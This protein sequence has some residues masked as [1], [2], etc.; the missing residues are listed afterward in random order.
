MIEPT[1]EMRRDFRAAM[2]RRS[3]E[4]VAAGE[5]FGGDAILNA[6]LAAVLA[7][8]ERE[9]CMELRGHVWHP[10]GERNQPLPLS[11]GRIQSYCG[12]VERP[13]AGHVW[14]TEPGRWC[15]GDEVRP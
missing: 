7:L 4:A 2:E 14:V 13:H 9:R 8:V 1:D 10:L 5:P 3:R 6:G 15:P 12:R 11:V